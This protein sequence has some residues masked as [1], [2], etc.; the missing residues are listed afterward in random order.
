MKAASRRNASRRTNPSLETLESRLLLSAFVST[1]GSGPW[2]SLSAW[3]TQDGG[4]VTRIPAAGDTVTINGKITVDVATTVGTGSGDAITL[5]SSAAMGDKTL[6]IAAP[7]TVQGSLMSKGKSV[8]DVLAGAGMDFDDAAG[9]R[10]Q[11]H[12]AGA[13]QVNLYFHGTSGNHCYLRTK[14]GTAGLTL[15]VRTDPGAN[16]ATNVGATY[17]DFS[18]INGPAGAYGLNV[19]PA[20]GARS[21]T[22]DHCTFTRTSFYAQVLTTLDTTSTPLTIS[23][24]IFTQSPIV[25]SGDGYTAAFYGHNLINLTADSLDA[26]SYMN[27]MKDVTSCVF[28]GVVWQDVGTTAPQ[29][30]TWSD[31]LYNITDIQNGFLQTR[32]G[33]YTRTYF[34]CPVDH[35]NNPHISEMISNNV[36]YN[37]VL[38]DAPLSDFVD[39][40]CMILGGGARYDSLQRCISLPTIGGSSPGQ[41]VSLSDPCAANIAFDHNTAALSTGVS[42]LWAD[43][44]HGGSTGGVTEFKSNIGYTQDS[45]PTGGKLIYCTTITDL[46]A[47]ANCDYNAKYRSVY[48][49]TSTGTPGTHDVN[50]QNPNFIDPT[51][52][53][54]NFYRTHA[55]ITPG[56]ATT[57]VPAAFEWMFQHPEL[58]PQMISWV[59]N[60]YI[61]TN[62]ALKA[63]HDNV[64]P[65]NGW[66]GAMEG[67]PVG[68]ANLDGKTNFQDYIILERNF[69]QA[70]MGWEG[71]DFNN[72]G[73][74]N[75]QDYIILER[76]FGTSYVSAA[77]TQDVATPVELAASVMATGGTDLPAST[78]VVG[79]VAPLC[80]LNGATTI[81]GM[82]STPFSAVGPAALPTMSSTGPT[83][84]TVTWP[85]A[86]K[87]QLPPVKGAADACMIDVLGAAIA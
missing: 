64:A 36:T 53:L 65:T 45:L 16:T 52:D 18:D 22:I 13:N 1:A 25:A 34:Y 42:G 2:S 43:T 49:M 62:L 24:S 57:D 11:I 77:P 6:T 8:V 10:P 30:I 20:D 38:F 39:D 61:P 79:P 80:V 69:G 27:M 54:T 63:A 59:S 87:W 17:T 66:I 84:R 75:F 76:N 31:N 83:L 23:N 9:A 12:C 41:G 33:T 71:G 29:F 40:A 37:Q 26:H 44:S 51:R 14:A 47:P 85:K 72:D 3:A 67:K 78:P 4:A 73:V 50:G 15:Y 86:Q 81:A 55:G 5:N 48:N 46:V 82:P 32:T 58:V 35:A 19:W 68:D 60:G 28:R 21:T 74:V 56:P 70:N 7:L